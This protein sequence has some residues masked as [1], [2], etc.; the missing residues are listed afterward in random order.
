MLSLKVIDYVYNTE[1]K[2]LDAAKVI[3]IFDWPDST[4]S[5]RT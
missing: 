1:K 2:Y 5:M 3:K 4:D